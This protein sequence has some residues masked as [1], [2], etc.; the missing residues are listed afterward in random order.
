MSGQ[1]QLTT[2]KKM[3]PD[4]EHIGT[5]YYG[6]LHPACRVPWLLR[7]YLYAAIGTTFLGNTLG[8]NW[9]LCGQSD[10]IIQW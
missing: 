9:L 3:L 10:I 1:L 2:A 7:K 4:Q 5:G 6:S 8:E